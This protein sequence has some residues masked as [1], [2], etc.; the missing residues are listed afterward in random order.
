MT[1]PEQSDPFGVPTAR[2]SSPTFLVDRVRAAVDAWRAQGYPKASP[3]TKRLLEFWFEEEHT[4]SGNPF[5]FYFCQREAVE[6]F[7]YLTE[8]APVRNGGDLLVYAD[9]PML[10]AP[11]DLTR[12]RLA[13]KMATGSGKTMAMALC[14]TWSYFHRRYEAGSQTANRFLMLAPNIIVFERLR[15]DFEGGIVFQTAPLLPSE[16]KPDFALT[17]VL[18]D[19]STPVTTDGVLVLT[20][21][22]RLYERPAAAPA[23]PVD[24]AIGPHVNRDVDAASAEA[25]F[26]RVSNLGDILVLNDEA[27]H[28]WSDKHR[29][30]QTIDALHAR[31]VARSDRDPRVFEVAAVW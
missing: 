14:L 16:F 29:W 11:A 18:Q 19:E 3:T 5:S 30:N 9:R 10:L 28:V 7:I 4:V 22:Q 2:L 15:S 25:F 13:F 6:T 21:I 12:S 23:N 20:N 17:T 1:G 27:H 8:A 31:G 26:K 24:A